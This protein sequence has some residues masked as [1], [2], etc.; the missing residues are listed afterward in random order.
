MKKSVLMFSLLSGTALMFPRL[1][2]ASGLPALTHTYTPEPKPAFQFEQP[3]KAFKTAAVC[4]LGAENCGDAG[5]GKDDEDYTIDT[6]QQCKNEGYTKL[7]C[8]SVQT[9]DG[10]C[11]YN[12]AYGLGCKCAPDLVSCTEEQTGVGESCDGKYVSCK[13]PAGVVE[14]QYGCKE[15]YTSPCETVCKKAYADNCHNRSSVSTPY[16][17]AEYWPDCSGKCKTAYNDNCRNR[18]EVSH[19]YGCESYYADCQ[20]KCE[21]AKS[22][23]NCQIGS[24]YY[25]DGSCALPE[26]H[27]TSKTVLGI[28]V[29][30]IDGGKHGQIMAPWPVDKNGNILKTAMNSAIDWCRQASHIPGLPEISSV[31]EAIKDYDSCG[32][33]DKLVAAGNASVYPA[34]WA[35][36]KYAPTPETK[37]KW[38]LPAAG[39]LA[40]IYDNLTVIQNATDALDI[41]SQNDYYGLTYL[42]DYGWSSTKNSI[43]APWHAQSGWLIPPEK[44]YGINAANPNGGYVW[45]V[46]GF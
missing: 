1:T 39:I 32:N 20:A 16:G 14:G 21:V 36:R 5:F 43:G 25:S 3:D 9:V 45:P 42:S 31:E 30:V 4:F 27:D 11:P 13:C 19:P 46:L 10:V 37:G 40:K 18:I 35:A 8:N 33:T 24:I 12:P 28:V 26:N 34:A 38:C 7:N 44:I 15:Y 23:P 22:K 17:C 41:F 29:H 6:G 2:I